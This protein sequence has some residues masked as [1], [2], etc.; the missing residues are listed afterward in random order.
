[1]KKEFQKEY[2]EY[3]KTITDGFAKICSFEGAES[4]LS[5]EGNKVSVMIYKNQEF[6]LEFDKYLRD[7]YR[8]ESHDERVKEFHKKRQESAEKF[9]NE[10]RI[11]YEE[12]VEKNKKIC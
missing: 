6:L 12:W 7:L 5:G 8:G 10:N 11:S 1:M 2:E 4:L 9:L 3:I